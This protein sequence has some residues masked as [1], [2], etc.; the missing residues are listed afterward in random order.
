MPR[1]LSVGQFLIRSVDAEQGLLEGRAPKIVAGRDVWK[2]I[3]PARSAPPKDAKVA[4]LLTI[5]T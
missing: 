1:L 3:T 5:Q 4:V 2:D